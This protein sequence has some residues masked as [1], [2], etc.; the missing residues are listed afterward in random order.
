M[1][2]GP[3][4]KTFVKEYDFN[5]STQ[6]SKLGMVLNFRGIIGRNNPVIDYSR[7]LGVII[8][9]DLTKKF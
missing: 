5:Y 7:R 6:Y 4:L 9:V 8:G 1:F 2:C 3:F